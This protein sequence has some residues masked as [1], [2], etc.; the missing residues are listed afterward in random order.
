MA[1]FNMGYPKRTGD[2][3]Q[4]LKNLYNFVCELSDRLAYSFRA[5][6]NSKTNKTTANTEEQ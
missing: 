2:D 6:G 3:S 5:I 4:D 1:E